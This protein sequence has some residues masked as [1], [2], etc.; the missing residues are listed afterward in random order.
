MKKQKGGIVNIVTATED[1]VKSMITLGKDIFKEIDS[2]THFKDDIN[3]GVS[4]KGIPNNST[5]SPTFT[6]PSL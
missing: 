1:V 3:R 4:S 6:A 5:P 2:I